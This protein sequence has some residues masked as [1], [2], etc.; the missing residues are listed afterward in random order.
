MITSTGIEWQTSEAD[1]PGNFTVTATQDDNPT[2]F[3][4]TIFVVL[5][6]ELNEPPVLDPIGNKTAAA[7]SEL[8]FTATASDPDLPPQVLTFSLGPTAPAGATIDSLTGAFSWTPT[9]D[10]VGDH[11]F[12]VV[13][14]DPGIS[15]VPGVPIL[16]L[17]DSETIT[18]TVGPP[19][20]GAVQVHVVETV[21]VMDVPAVATEAVPPTPA[22]VHVVETVQVTDVPT[23]MTEAPGPVQV[24][25]VET[26]QVTDVPAV[27]TEAPAPVQ[28]HVVETVQVTDVAA[29]PTLDDGDGIAPAIDG[30]FENQSFV[31]EADVFSNRF[32]DEQLGGATFGV[33]TDRQGQQLTIV[34]GAPPEEGVVLVTSAGL[35]EV[36]L[37]VCADSRE[38]VVSPSTTATITCGSVTIAVGTGSGDRAACR[39]RADDPCRRDRDDYGGRWRDLHRD[40]AGQQRPSSAEPG[41]RA[42]ADPA[43]RL[44]IAGAGL[45]R[46]RERRRG[47]LAGGCSAGCQGAADAAGTPAV[48]SRGRS[49]QRWPSRQ[50]GSRYHA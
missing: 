16:P 6:A 13:V 45:P 37:E 25:V 12:D 18:V 46:R 35:G 48:G 39:R 44:G 2:N 1:G 27:T 26:V 49:Q 7:G 3:T 5:V 43:G 28:I 33:I 30:V 17:S 10:Q 9:P 34:D 32:T 19:G 41:R 31:S 11:T 20:S 4:S 29:P 22:Q 42:S 38:V 21:H 47:H 50:G 36:H 8:T 14:A 23:A 24:H 40:V 15:P